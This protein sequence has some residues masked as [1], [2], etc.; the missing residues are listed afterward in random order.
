MERKQKRIKEHSI[1]FGTLKKCT[2]HIKANFFCLHLQEK[3]TDRQ[4]FIFILIIF[5]VETTKSIAELYLFFCLI[6][7]SI[8]ED[9]QFYFYILFYII[10]DPFIFNSNSI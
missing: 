10:L 8:L 7:H 1:F 2:E 5:I 6:W 3:Y 4:F 9:Y